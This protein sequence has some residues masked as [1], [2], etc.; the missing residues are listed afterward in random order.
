[1][2]TLSQIRKQLQSVKNIRQIASSMEMV[3]S[4]R[5]RKAQIKARQAQFYILKTRQ[6][7]ERLQH[8]ST[9]YKHPLFEQR[10]VK[11]TGLVI[12]ASDKGL[13]GAY[14]TRIFFEAD[15]FLKKYAHE[16]VELLLFGKKAVHYFRKKHFTIIQKQEGWSGKITLEEIRTFSDTLCDLFLQ[17]QLDAIWFIYTKFHNLMSREVACEQFLPAGRAQNDEKKD[18]A[19]FIFEPN[20]EEIYHF[21]L[22]RYCLTKV[23]SM[24]NQS[25]ASELAARIFAM[26]AASNNAGEMMD[27]L[28]LERNKFRQAGITREILETTSSLGN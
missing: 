7:L 21:L 4:A 1:M 27:R 24:L 9:D 26:Q 25:Y 20:L 3:A 2:S 19:N 11:K 13:C 5:L 15:R 8:A 14:N 22:A 17:K 6:I 18:A 23:E 12:I 16:N 28:T 10:K